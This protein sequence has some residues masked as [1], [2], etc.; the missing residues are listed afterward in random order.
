MNHWSLVPY[1]V[2]ARLQIDGS[3]ALPIQHDEP[4]G[5]DK[6]NWLPAPQVGFAMTIEAVWSCTRGSGTMRLVRL[7]EGCGLGAALAHGGSARRSRLQSGGCLRWCSKS[8]GRVAQGALRR[9][10]PIALP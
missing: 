3:F 8:G 5:P 4:Q 2:K 1:Q 6:V 10:V 7:L 9:G